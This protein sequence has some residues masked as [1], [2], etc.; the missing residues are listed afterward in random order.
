[1]TL[2][3]VRDSGAGDSMERLFNDS[4]TIQRFRSS[5]LGPH[6]QQLAEELASQG[7]ARCDSRLRL[8]IAH[9][10]GLWLS[11]CHIQIPNVN[12]SDADRYVAK[13]GNIKQGDAISVRMLLDI[14]VREGL[15]RP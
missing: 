8:R 3:S 10:F 7:Y 2:T 14:L 9:Q 6:I 11:R 5:P 15:A 4:R 1:M 13:Y 12:T